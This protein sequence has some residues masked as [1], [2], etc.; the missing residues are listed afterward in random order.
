MK[1]LDCPL[2][3]ASDFEFVITLS[4]VVGLLVLFVI[5]V[6]VFCRLISDWWKDQQ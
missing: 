1:V 2:L 3:I 6:L 4:D 5:L